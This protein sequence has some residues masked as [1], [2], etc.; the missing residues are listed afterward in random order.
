MNPRR[1]EVADRLHSASLHLIRVVR[2]VDAEM[3]LSP[4][5]SSVLSVLVFGGPRTVGGLARAEGVRSPTMTALVDGL[6]AEGL[7]RRRP[8]PHDARSVLVDATAKGRRILVRGRERR[9]ALLDS[10]LADAREADIAV[11]DRAAGLM[12][13]AVAAHLGPATGEEGLRRPRR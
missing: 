9:V 5:R 10:L 2:T 6:E 8:S 11:L 1:Q 7:V 4:A 12:E 13:A 3:G